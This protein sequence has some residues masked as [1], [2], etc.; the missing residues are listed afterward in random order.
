[1]G[2]TAPVIPSV[3]C[4]FGHGVHPPTATPLALYVSA[5]HARQTSPMAITKEPGSHSLHASLGYADNTD[6]FGLHVRLSPD[7]DNMPP[8]GSATHFINPPVK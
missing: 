8:A 5:G 7:D 1:M 6:Q 3:V 4:L 2:D